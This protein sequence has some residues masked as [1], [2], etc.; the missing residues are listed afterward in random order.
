M[1]SSTGH[2]SS[3]DSSVFT[4]YFF[5]SSPATRRHHA[6]PIPTDDNGGGG[7]VAQEALYLAVPAL[8]LSLSVPIAAPGAVAMARHFEPALAPASK[9]HQFT[10]GL[11]PTVRAN[12]LLSRAPKLS[13]LRLLPA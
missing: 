13:D 5:L 1:L 12:R 3:R 6:G 11:N 2:P 9:P 4:A 8:L 7:D 10:S